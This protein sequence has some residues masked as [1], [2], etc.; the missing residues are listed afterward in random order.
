M[1]VPAEEVSL[2]GYGENFRKQ[3]EEAK[4]DTSVPAEEPALTGYQIEARE[5]L[6][7]AYKGKRIVIITP[8][9]EF[10]DSDIAEARESL[11][12][13]FGASGFMIVHASMMVDQLSTEKLRPEELR[14]PTPP[15]A[16]R[17][18]VNLDW[19]ETRVER[20]GYGRDGRKGWQTCH[21]PEQR[22][23]RPR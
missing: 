2:Q 6:E 7:E 13:A 21:G 10:T 18:T 9:G 11:S 8:N 1:H 16:H 19:S 12:R 17:Y 14:P 20:T 5:E 4:H 22:R 15:E 3:M 23:K